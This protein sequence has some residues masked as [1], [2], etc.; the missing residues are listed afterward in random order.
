M[1]KRLKR[2]MALAQKEAIQILRDRSTLMMILALPLVELLLF[3]YA[4]D[5]TVDH[6]PTAVADLSLDAESRGLIDALEVSGYFDVALYLESE[7]QVIRAIDEGRVS[8]GVVIPPNFAAQV[9]RGH[10]QVLILL[11]GSNSFIVQSGYSAAGAVVQARAMDVLVAQLDRRGGSLG[12]W[13]M[14]S[15]TR[16]LYNPN[17]DDLIFIVPGLA[18][19]LLQFTAINLTALA[20]VRERELGTIEQLLATPVRPM[21]LLISKVVPNAV[22]STVAMLAVVL[23]GIFWFGVPFQGDPWLFGWLSLLFI[24]SGLG[25]GL[26][27]STVAQS[28]KQAQQITMLLMLLS[29]LLTGFIYPRAPMPPAIKVV[30]SLIPLTYFIRIIRGIFTKGIGLAFMWQDVVALVVYGA[31]VMVVA[32]ATF[33]RRLD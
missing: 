23:V 20:V 31:V 9:G 3:A 22:V 18:A 32:A 4:V 8:A 25:V 16:V 2:L 19:M 30:S 26:L 27:I 5:M 11:D 29:L 14:V 10:G 33:K 7:A 17:M 28:Q 1:G 24:V 6:I 13:P 12:A 15:S 21:E